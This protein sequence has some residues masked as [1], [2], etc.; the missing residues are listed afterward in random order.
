VAEPIGIQFGDRLERFLLHAG[1]FDAFQ[2]ER[3]HFRAC[4]HEGNE[5]KATLGM[6]QSVRMDPAYFFPL[7][8]EGVIARRDDMPSEDSVEQPGRQTQERA[9]CPVPSRAK[10]P[11]S[12][13]A[14]WALAA[15]G[16]TPAAFGRRCIPPPPQRGCRVGGPGSGCVAPR[17]NT[18]G[19]LARRALP[20]GRIAALGATLDFHHGLLASS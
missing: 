3:P 7:A 11:R 17:S 16:E 6:N 15:P 9:C 18:P 13:R 1:A 2:R 12:S 8:L 10:A 20:A 5:V 14:S 19:I 4:R